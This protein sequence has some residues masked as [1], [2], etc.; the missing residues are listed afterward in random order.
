M[1]LEQEFSTDYKYGFRD[2][3]APVYKSKKGLSKE[4]V[5]EISAMKNEPEWMHQYRLKSL[6]HFM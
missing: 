5:E 4:I 2:A 6:E 3:E 1:A